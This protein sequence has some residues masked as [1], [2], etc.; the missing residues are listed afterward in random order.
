MMSVLVFNG[1]SATGHAVKNKNSHQ[2]WSQV[3]QATLQIPTST[4]YSA[5]LWPRGL[6]PFRVARYGLFKATL[7]AVALFR[8]YTTSMHSRKIHMKGC[9]PKP[10]IMASATYA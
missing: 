8:Q 1:M 9:I 3:L 2:L 7:Q 6:N 5:A 4:F 10:M